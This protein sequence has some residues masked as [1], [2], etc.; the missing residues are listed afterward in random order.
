MIKP[1]E[2]FS[3]TDSECFVIFSLYQN[4]RSPTKT[5]IHLIITLVINWHR[6]YFFRCFIAH[7]LLYTSFPNKHFCKKYVKSLACWKF[8]YC[9]HRRTHLD[10]HWATVT[11]T[12]LSFYKNN[13]TADINQRSAR[14]YLFPSKN[15]AATTADTLLQFL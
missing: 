8:I 3:L 14:N 4:I 6:I 1:Q 5:N 10:T 15:Q 12:D 13:S 9:S 7:Y 2:R 11:L